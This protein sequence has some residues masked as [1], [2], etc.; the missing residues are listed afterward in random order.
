[1]AASLVLEQ[2]RVALLRLFF[3]R[4]LGPEACRARPPAKS[5]GA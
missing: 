4:Q 5:C 3:G 1:V 2:R